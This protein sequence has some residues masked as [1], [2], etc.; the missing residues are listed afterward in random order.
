MVA[1][2]QHC[3]QCG[4][5]RLVLREAVYDGF[6]RVGEKRLCSVCRTE[7]DAPAEAPEGKPTAKLFA[8]EDRPRKPRIEGWEEA[9]Q[10]CRHCRHYIVNPFT[11]RCGLHMREVAAT[12]TCPDF[13]A[14]EEEAEGSGR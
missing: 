5:D 13:T 8:P 4:E 10:I 12:D 3:P 11:Q 14:R 2:T 9:K 1:A 6:T 7:L